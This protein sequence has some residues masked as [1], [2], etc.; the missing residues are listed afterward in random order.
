MLLDAV[1]AA[2]HHPHEYGNEQNQRLVFFKA[3]H[4]VSYA[5]MLATSQDSLL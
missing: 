3:V 4:G 5:K 1:D 2:G